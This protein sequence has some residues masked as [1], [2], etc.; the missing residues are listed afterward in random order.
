MAGR[1]RYKESL[2]ALLAVGVVIAVVA[3]VLVVLVNVDK[4]APVAAPPTTTT[5]TTTTTSPTKTKPKPPSRLPA[6]LVVK[7]DNVA[8]ARPATG[9]GSA[10]AIYVEPVEG[11]L[12][13]LLA[14]YWGKRP[15]VVGPVRSARETD[16]QLVGYMRRPVLAY[17]GSAR[18]IKRV[19]LAADVVHANPTTVGRAFYRAGGNPIPH[20]MYVDPQ[21]LP[22]TPG[23]G[24]PL[25]TGKAPKGGKLVS[26]RHVSYRAAS[27]DFKWSWGAKRWSISVDGG[28]MYSTESGR[29]SASTVVVQR[30]RIV[31]GQKVRASGGGY[32]PVARTVGRG[33]ATVLRNGRAF[34]GYWWRPSKGRETVY[35]TKNGDRIP[36]ARGKVWVL[37]VPSR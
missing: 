16:L 35:R 21:R 5:T 17:S 14:V 26:S 19:L 10:D 33:R 20:N 1:R 15:G 28:P 37:L 13:R 4:P 29:L 12:T 3:V 30:V 9:L 8:Q 18:R 22:S 36:L 6:A 34:E 25:R 31:S 27:F 2:I 32:S 7:I 23:V 11:G 24:T